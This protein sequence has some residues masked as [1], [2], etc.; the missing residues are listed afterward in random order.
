MLGINIDNVEVVAVD[1]NRNKILV[2]INKTCFWLGI[3]SFS[4]DFNYLLQEILIYSRD[5]VFQ[6]YIAVLLID[7]L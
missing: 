6:F 5:H 4:Y 1:P 3:Y 2:I 7:Q